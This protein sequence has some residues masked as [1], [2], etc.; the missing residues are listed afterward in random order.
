MGLVARPRVTAS[1]TAVQPCPHCGAEVTV[2]AT[3]VPGGGDMN[4]D[5]A[6]RIDAYEE[7]ELGDDEIVRLFQ[8]LVDTG[9]AWEL[10][11]HYGRRAVSL[12]EQGLVR[13]DPSGRPGTEAP[14]AQEC[15]PG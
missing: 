1:A 14:D 3:L 10:Q 2:L 8:E 15:T 11:G 6:R 5:L 9:L 13:S 4:P 12:I 7:G